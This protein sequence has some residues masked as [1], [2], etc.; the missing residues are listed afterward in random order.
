[1]VFLVLIGSLVIV[2]VILK[3]LHREDTAADLVEKKA[4][5]NN[6]DDNICCGLHDICSKS[7]QRIDLPI[8]FDDEELDRF[9]GMDDITYS[10]GEIDEFREILHTLPPGEIVLWQDSL[11][12]RN[13]AV[14]DEIRDEMIILLDEF[15]VKKYD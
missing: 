6:A 12:A 2:G 3:I 9:V 7:A 14:P 4:V 8:Y 10:P 11:T 13:I 1:M 15:A 5:D